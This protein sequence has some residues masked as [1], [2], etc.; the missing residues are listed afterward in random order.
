MR[1]F[2]DGWTSS[3][4]AR[5]RKRQAALLCGLTVALCTPAY[6]AH[7]QDSIPRL[8]PVVTVTRD[9]GRSALEVPY[10]ISETRPDSA[11]PGQSHLLAEQTLFLLP[12]VTVAN[13]TNPSQDTRISIRGFGA[14]SQFGV[15][16][17]RI[18]RDGMPLTLP[19]GQTP[20][21]Y[22]DLESV[23]RV[24]AIRGAASALYGNAGGGVIDL[25]SAVPPLMPVAG[26]IRSW[27]GDYGTRRVTGVVGGSTDAMFY[28]A[29]VGHT[30]ADNFRLY[31]RQEL[32]NGYARVGTTLAGTDFV[33]QGLGLD[34][35]TAQNPG[36]LTV[37][38]LGNPQLPDSSSVRKLA[39]KAVKQF[40]LGLSATHPFEDARGGELFAQVYGGT[41]DLYNPLT[42]A[43]VDVGRVQYGGSLRATMPMNV[44]VR[45]RISIGADGAMQN[46]LRK[47]WANC[48]A[49][50]AVSASCPTLPSEKGALQ[51]DQR[52]I[53]SSVGPYLRDEFAL[54]DRVNLSGG[55]RADLVR[56]QLQ[57]HFLTDGRDD[58]GTRVLHAVSPM[59]GGVVK[60]GPVSA[61]YANVGSAFET[62]TT[63]ELGNQPNGNAG[64]NYDLKPQY[65]TTYET[66]FKGLLLSRV[67]YD[68][69]LFDTEVRDELIPFGVPGGNG[70]TYYRNA[71][72]TRRNGVEVSGGTEVGDLA[73]SAAYTYSHFR[74]RDFPSAGVQFAG[75]V[76]PGIPEQQLEASA[77][78]RLS[79]LFATVEGLAKSAVYVDDA[80]TARAAGFAVYNV[81]VGADGIG[82]M[83]W[84]TPVVSVQ[85]LFNRNYVGSV[86]VNAAGTPTTA[87]FYEPGA[88]RTLLVGLSVGAGR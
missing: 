65:S 39:R 68:L 20:I 88:G 82:R 36:A 26:Q 87:K 9:I 37:G 57:D 45:Q 70:R 77:T 33:L 40:Q 64:L 81:R 11:R 7:A 79:S 13:R 76:I 69:A 78:W 6:S 50:A 61:L 31:S 72:Q 25:R 62:P 74:F 53:V 16:S 21:D 27:I 67:Q 38:Q 14:R 19:D 44:V 80:N 56:F 49:V 4:P 5:R 54:G 43:V 35:P 41:R 48:N 66:G 59:I 60:L 47:N 52:E 23:G 63:T 8:P 86:A 18:L 10:A 85:N 24:E 73:V 12:G 84:L 42:F 51:L 30:L 58:S 46:D 1:N 55:V 22:L 28:Q 2:R 83:F 75:N 15:R 71:G 3:E 29:N 17:V 32:T 34:M